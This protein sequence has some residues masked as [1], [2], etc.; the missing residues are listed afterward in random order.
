MSHLLDR[1]SPGPPWD[2]AL[3]MPA[4]CSYAAD[5]AAELSLK[6]ESTMSVYA[7]KNAKGQPTGQWVVEVTRNGQRLPRKAFSDIAEAKRYEEALMA[8]E[9]AYDGSMPPVR[10]LEPPRAYTVGDL[11][12][13]SQKLW[14]GQKDEKQSLQ[15]FND[16]MDML[17]LDQPLASIRATQMDEFVDQLRDKS[18]T[19]ATIK[20]YLAVVSKAF[21]K[22]VRGDLLIAKPPMPEGLK[23]SAI[24]DA[25]ITEEDDKRIMAWFEAKGS[26]DLV[27]VINVL[28][29]TG[30]RVGEVVQLKPADFDTVNGEVTIGNWE[31]STKNGDKRINILPPDVMERAIAL[32]KVGWPSYRRILMAIHRCRKG[33][34]IKYELTP[35]TCRHTVVTRLSR[36]GVPV[37]TI[38]KQVGHKSIATT[39]RYTHTNMDDLHTASNV[40]SRSS[41][42]ETA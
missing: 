22:A 25:E 42:S 31:G 21:K 37:A 24:R 11:K 32:A 9:V 30:M 27:I 28:L 13:D 26:P 36:A 12:R 34:G 38:M 7:K 6:D 1:R 17:G 41:V 40:L 39:K 2:E 4:S 20:R 15:R 35:H 19:D 10:L 33:L 29:S 18:L 23:D 8:M 14:R 3:L 16:S 5:A